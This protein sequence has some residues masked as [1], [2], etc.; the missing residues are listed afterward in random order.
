MNGINIRI[1]KNSKFETTNQI[2]IFTRNGVEVLDH[3]AKLLVL[4]L[5]YGSD[6]GVGVTGRQRNVCACE[7]V[8]IIY[9]YICIQCSL[10][11]TEVTCALTKLRGFVR[12]KPCR[13]GGEG[14]GTAAAAHAYVE[15]MQLF[16]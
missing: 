1:I 14:G 5:D 13:V 4:L 12:Y 2:I 8:Y 10:S 7:C 3:I 15:K 11:T 9:I 16:E 6:D